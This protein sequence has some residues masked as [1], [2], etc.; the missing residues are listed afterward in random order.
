MYAD[1]LVLC[2]KSEEGQKVIVERFVEVCRGRVLKVKADMSK[3]MGTD[4]D[5]GL[6]CEIRVDGTRLEQLSEF[7]Y[8]GCALNES[9][10]DDA[11]CRSKVDSGKKVA[12]AIKPMVNGRDLQLECARALHYGLLV[13]V[14]FY[15]KENNM[16]RKGEIYD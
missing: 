4:G 13:P 11:E 8:L 5:E 15:G 6:E 10:T 16:E 2:G 14:L 7:K 1:D 9:G 3:V 12:G